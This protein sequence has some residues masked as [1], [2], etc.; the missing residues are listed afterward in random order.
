MTKQERHLWYD[1]LKAYPV[2]F[3]RQ[4][5]IDCYI[6][7]FYCSAAKLVIELDGI[8]HFTEGGRNYDENRTFCLERHSLTV[9]RFSNAEID[10]DFAAVCAK[11]DTV[12]RKL[13]DK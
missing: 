3:V 8:Q 5:I 10:R 7:D 1:F 4:R 6:A 9:L 13:T 11:I 2:R 12:V